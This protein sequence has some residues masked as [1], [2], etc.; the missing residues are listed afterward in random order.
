MPVRR[1]PGSPIARRPR[2]WPARRPSP[3]RGYVFGARGLGGVRC[4]FAQTG[5]EFRASAVAARA[6]ERVAVQA[7][8]RVGGEQVHV[9]GEEGE[10]LR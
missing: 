6:V 5:G 3:V 9:G 1:S 7:E 4:E 8:L 10:A 2:A